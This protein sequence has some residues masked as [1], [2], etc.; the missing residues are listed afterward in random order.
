MITRN[1]LMTP[2]PTPVPSFVR[3]SLSRQILHH[4][5]GEFQEILGA[6][7]GGLKSIFC[8]ENPVLILASSGTGAMEAAVNNLFVK[9]DK[10][11]AIVGGKFGER[12]A[13]IAKSFSLDVVEMNVEWGSAPLPED[14]AKILDENRGI[15][16]VL[17][18]LCETSTATV[19]DI[20]KIAKITK[21]KDIFLIVDAVSGLGQDVLF[22]DRWG[23]D[24]VVSGSQKGLMLPP[25]LSFLSLSKKAQSAIGASDL[26]KY[27]FDLKKAL[28]SYAKNDTPYTPAVSLIVGLK[29]AIDAINKEG[30]EFRWK[31]FEK[32]AY[33]T[34]EAAKALGL[35]VFSSAPSASVTA[36][37]SPED[38]RSSDIV[39][40]LREK[41]GVS[42]AGGQDNFKDKIFRIAHMGWINEQDLIDCFLLLEKVLKD[43]GYRFNQGASVS[44]LKEVFHG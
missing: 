18:T 37:V 1:I 24:V 21:E 25:G 39:K 12:W 14:L 28:K 11:L 36:I 16:G 22:T 33:G 15:K 8:T 38:I 5:T 13:E 4:R 20:E 19:F 35:E 6:V 27:Y 29:E 31:K 44:R 2:G 42:I 41:H 34:R 10:A 9:G 23:V 7:Y 40:I 30:I 43:L 26:P 3:E 17:T 32:M